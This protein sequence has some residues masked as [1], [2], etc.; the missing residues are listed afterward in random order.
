MVVWPAWVIDSPR[1]I[2]SQRASLRPVHLR[3][4]VHRRRRHICPVLSQLAHDQVELVLVVLRQRARAGELREQ[5]AR[6]DGQ[7]VALEL[8]V[9]VAEG[10]L[11]RV[12]VRVRVRVRVRVLVRV[13]VR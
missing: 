2:D 9:Q 6:R 10:D 13:R 12:G 11:V 8:E 4:R 5:A 3:R 1:S 7:R